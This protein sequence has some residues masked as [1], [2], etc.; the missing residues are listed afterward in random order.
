MLSAAAGLG[1][2]AWDQLDERGGLHAKSSSSQTLELYTALLGLIRSR[3]GAEGPTTGTAHA[4]VFSAAAGLGHYAWDQMDERGG[5]RSVLRRLDLLDPGPDDHSA[6]EGAS[7]SCSH[8]EIESRRP[9][10]S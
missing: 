9:Q 3:R 4:L 7:H 1:H 10:L 8:N 2:Y 5:L 6:S